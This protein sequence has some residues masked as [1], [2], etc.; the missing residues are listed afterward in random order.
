MCARLNMYHVLDI[1]WVSEIMVYGLLCALY[2]SYIVSLEIWVACVCGNLGLV[3]A[4]I[5]H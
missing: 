3:C 2:V 5:Y 1:C 4:P